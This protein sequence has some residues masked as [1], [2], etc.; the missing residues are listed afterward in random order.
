MVIPQ[1]R[2]ESRDEWN[3]ELVWGETESAASARNKHAIDVKPDSIYKPIECPER[4]FKELFVPKRLEESLPFASKPKNETTQK[5]K[6]HVSKRDVVM[7]EADEREKHIFIEALNSIRK[8][9]LA[10]R[11]MKNAKRMQDR[12]KK[13]ATKEQA[14]KEKHKIDKKHKYRSEGKKESAREK[15]KDRS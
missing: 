10:L 9:K 5:K 15:K 13:N 11:R 2:D 3:R 4:K 1:S 8:E 14:L 6:D 7:L 12:A